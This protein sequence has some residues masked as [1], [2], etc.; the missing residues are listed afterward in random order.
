MNNLFRRGLAL[1]LSVAMLSSGLHAQNNDATGGQEKLQYEAKVGDVP[2]KPMPKLT[3]IHQEGQAKVKKPGVP[4]AEEIEAAKKNNKNLKPLTPAQQKAQEEEVRRATAKR[5]AEVAAIENIPRI[6]VDVCVYGG[7]SAGVISAY[8][9]AK[10]GKKPVLIEPSNHLGGMTASGLGSTDIGNKYAITGLARDFYRRLGKHYN[11]FES[12]T[13]EPKVAENLFDDYV[14]RGGN[15]PVY[16]KMRVLKVHKNGPKILEVEFESADKPGQ[17][18]LFVK[19]KHFI[20][21][22]YEGDL[23]ALAKCSYHVGRE[24]NKEFNE[25][26]NGVQLQHL[27]QFPD[28]I[29]PY[30]VEGKPESGLLWGISSAKV[31]PNGTGDKMVQAYNYRICL[32]KDPKNM[33]PFTAPKGYDPKTYALLGRLIEKSKWKTVKNYLLINDMPNQK[34][35]VNHKGGFSIDMIGEN[36]DYPEA[37]YKRREEIALKHTNYIKGLFFYL[38]NDPSLPEE[39]RASM[40]EYGYPKDEFLDNEGFPHQMYVREARR[41][42]GELVMTQHHCEAKEV[43]EDGVGMAAYTMDSHNCQRIVVNGMVKN[44]GNVEVSVGG[45]PYP[46]SYRAIIPKKEQCTNLLVPVCLSATHIAY[47]SIRM[48]PVFMVLGQSAA[49]AACMAIDR[50]LTRLHDVDVKAL[51]QELKNNPLADGSTAEILVDDSYTEQVEYSKAWKKGAEDGAKYGTSFLFADST[52]APTDWVK[53]KPNTVKAGKY[54]VYYYCGGVKKRGYFDGALTPKM[55]LKIKHVKGEE[56]KIFNPG[57]HFNEW[58]DAGVYEFKVGAQ[59]ITASVMVNK[60]ITPADAV[61]LVPEFK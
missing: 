1:L 6:E 9:V 3:P 5:D 40:R 19:A 21:C 13:F 49:V 41:L 51:Q 39:T 32:T 12:W 8:T 61:L 30:V 35:D 24:D 52:A 22:T 48:E 38:A 58:Y 2:A 57:E 26:L 31:Q 45:N 20:D 17:A 50:K 10:Y 33:I 18:A 47:G 23:M 7:I 14:K 15:F 44:E 4:T 29:D 59:E 27:H 43:V 34:T 53:F 36:W 54:R 56:A 16:K 42:R 28:G 55:A 11:R 37:N 60:G 25:T 46:V